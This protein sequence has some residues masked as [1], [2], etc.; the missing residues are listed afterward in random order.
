MYVVASYCYEL[1]VCIYVYVCVYCLHVCPV[2]MLHFYWV[3]VSKKVAY[4]TVSKVKY[5]VSYRTENTWYQPSA[6]WAIGLQN[7]QVPSKNFQFLHCTWEPPMD[8]QR[9]LCPVVCFY[10]GLLSV[11]LV[12]FVNLCNIIHEPWLRAHVCVMC[13]YHVSV[14]CARVCNTM[15]ICSWVHAW[16]IHTNTL[17]L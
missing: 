5:S 6:S 16:Q 10:T 4:L 1:L 13:A 9:N 14:C 12:G 15:Y 17:S 3:L 2:L 7:M 8:L 11:S